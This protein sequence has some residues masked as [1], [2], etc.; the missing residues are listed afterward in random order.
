LG[1]GKSTGLVIAAG[2]AQVLGILI[3]HGTLAQVVWV[4]VIVMAVL[5]ILLLGYYFFTEY[6]SRLALMQAV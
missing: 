3:F 2:L 5:F 1:A 6:K 4:Q